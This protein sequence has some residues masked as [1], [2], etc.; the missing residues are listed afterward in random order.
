MSKLKIVHAYNE[1]GEW[2][3]ELDKVLPLDAT[4]PSGYTAEPVPQP[5]WKP[6]FKNGKWIETDIES[7]ENWLATKD[8]PVEPHKTEIELLQD[9]NLD[10]KLALAEIAE[11]QEATK[12]EM[13]LALAEMAEALFGGE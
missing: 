13:Q 9:E 5:C 4:I 12:T 8:L 7:Y 10:L 6:V 2:V 3:S 1:K 11:T